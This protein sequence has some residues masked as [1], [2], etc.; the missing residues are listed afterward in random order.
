MAQTIGQSNQ[1]GTKKVTLLQHT[2]EPGY[3]SLFETILF[4]DLI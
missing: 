4:P 2:I 1:V 3:F